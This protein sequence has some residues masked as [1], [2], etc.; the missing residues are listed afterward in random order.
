VIF[1]TFMYILGI[2]TL[3]MPLGEEVKSLSKVSFNSSRQ[4]NNSQSFLYGEWGW[5]GGTGFSS[6]VAIGSDGG[7]TYTRRPWLVDGSNGTYASTF[8]GNFLNLSLGYLIGFTYDPNNQPEPQSQPTR[9]HMRPSHL[10]HPFH[11][12]SDFIKKNSW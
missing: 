4:K 10:V 11:L 1:L 2:E 5:D 6:G 8:G 12:L 7:K 3:L 9:H